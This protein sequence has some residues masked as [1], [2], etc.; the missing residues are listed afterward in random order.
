M[1][2]A[3]VVCHL[4][5]NAEHNRL[6]D[7]LKSR[8]GKD[9]RDILRDA[10]KLA[11]SK[12]LEPARYRWID[13]NHRI[14]NIDLPVDIAQEAKK[15]WGRK[16]TPVAVS[17]IL[18]LTRTEGVAQHPIDLHGPADEIRRLTGEVRK[19]YLSLQD[20]SK[21]LSTEGKPETVTDSASPARA[22]RDTLGKLAEQLNYFKR[23]TD[24]DRRKFREVVDPVDVGYITAL[25]K[26]LFDEEGFQRW[27]L[28]TEFV[29]GNRTN[30]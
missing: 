7:E 24:A 22:V 30:D 16:L 10:I 13:K 26:A 12:D 3:R 29:M 2:E 15:R 20:I 27:I 5:F 11:L 6:L 1:G 9:K 18:E 14:F 4:T 28:A 21:K 17:G 8:T 25:L 19:I 23:G